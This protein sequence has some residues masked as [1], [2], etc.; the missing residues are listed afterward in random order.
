VTVKATAAGILLILTLIDPQES[1]SRWVE[2]LGS[3]NVEKRD[4]AT[5]HLE[6]L[7]PGALQQLAKAASEAKDIE[8]KGRLG[9]IVRNIR[10]RAE[11]AKVFGE[12]KRVTLDVTEEPIANVLAD[13]GKSLGETITG[14]NLHLKKPIALHLHQATL[15]EALDLLAQ[16]AEARVEYSRWPTQIVVEPGAQAALPVTYLEQFRVGVVEVQRI[17]HREPHHQDSVVMVVLEVRHQRNMH[18]SADVFTKGFTLD[19]LK[20]AKGNDARAERPTWGGSMHLSGRPFALQEAFFVRADAEGPITVSGSV[21]LPF[22]WEVKDLTLPL[23]GD[24]REVTEGSCVIKIGGFSQSV[25]STSLTLEA[26]AIE[27]GHA[28]RHLE[29]DKII[30]VDESGAKHPSQSRSGG[31]SGA[32]WSWDFELPAGIRKPKSISFRWVSEFKNVEIPFRF[33]NVTLPLP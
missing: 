24:H 16:A 31:G 30:L 23:E 15:W 8:V 2:R 27:G 6:R 33:E 13:L 11:F 12:T 19:E 32:T 20:D 10:K 18:P 21:Q 17:E 9:Q 7:G 3:E 28:K 25:A 5:R 29:D 22:A 14:E 4:Q 1:F 26:S